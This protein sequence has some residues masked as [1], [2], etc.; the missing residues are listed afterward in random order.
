MG[1][2]TGKPNPSAEGLNFAGTPASPGR[3]QQAPALQS[4][5]VAANESLDAELGYAAGPPEPRGV[6]QMED[7]AGAGTEPRARARSGR[8]SSGSE[9]QKRVLPHLLSSVGLHG[10]GMHSSTSRRSSIRAARRRIDSMASAPTGSSVTASQKEHRES[11]LAQEAGDETGAGQGQA[12]VGQG[13]DEPVQSSARTSTSSKSLALQHVAANRQESRSDSKFARSADRSPPAAG[14]MKRGLD[15]VLSDCASGSSLQQDWPS[16]VQIDSSQQQ[17][18]L[19]CDSVDRHGARLGSSAGTATALD[20]GG[21]PPCHSKECSAPAAINATGRLETEDPHRQ[22]PAS[23]IDEFDSDSSNMQLD[24]REMYSDLPEEVSRIVPAISAADPLVARRPPY[25]G[26]SHEHLRS[27]AE[28]KPGAGAG[29]PSSGGLDLESQKSSRKDD[30]VVAENL[31]VLAG[32]K[33]SDCE[34]RSRNHSS[35][36]PTNS[37]GGS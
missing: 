4:S 33:H 15:P 37:L 12:L 27:S 11:K 7:S 25:S 17:V 9:D 22:V 1:S 26:A 24:L 20:G 5:M 35:A 16:A 10:F 28:S 32:Q 8:A 23:S 18:Q 3:A 30:P 2:S 14:Q 13:L 36:H 6:Q 29:F 31:P 19:P 21:G 34:P